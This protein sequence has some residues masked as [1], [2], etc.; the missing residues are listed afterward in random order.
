MWLLQWEGVDHT[1]CSKCQEAIK[2]FQANLKSPPP[3][4]IV[5]ATDAKFRKQ[6]QEL[7]NRMIKV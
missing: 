2:S 6:L 1:H 7:H 3:P 5:M 4:K